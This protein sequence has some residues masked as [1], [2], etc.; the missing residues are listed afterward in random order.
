MLP[1]QYYRIELPSETDTDKETV[2]QL[3]ITLQ[4]VLQYEKTICPFRRGFT[5]DLPETPEQPIKRPTRVSTEPVKKWKLDKVW[6][7]EDWTPEAVQI[8]ETPLSRPGSVIMTQSSDRSASSSP[9]P[10]PQTSESNSPSLNPQTSERQ[11]PSPNTPTSDDETLSEED[12]Q[13]APLPDVRPRALSNMRSVTAPGKLNLQPVSVANRLPAIDLDGSMRGTVDAQKVDTIVEQFAKLPLTSD[14]DTTSNVLQDDSE[15]G[16]DRIDSANLEMDPKDLPGKKETD[17]EEEL[18]APISAVTDCTDNYCFSEDN[19]V[20]HPI[21]SKMSTPSLSS[22]SERHSWQD[23][24]TPPETIRLRYPHKAVPQQTISE[25]VLSHTSS[26]PPARR[27]ASHYAEHQASSGVVRKTFTI[28]TSPPSYLVNI[29][30]QMAGR[31]A[32]GALSLTIPS[33]QGAHRR[34]PGSWDLSDDEDVWANES[35]EA[36]VTEKAA[37]NKERRKTQMSEG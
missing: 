25:Q 1:E 10:N 33:P 9:S 3:K 32:N 11:S 36:Q 18:G 19:I 34:I 35:P 4:K 13:V 6:R 24:V 14:S 29:M 8:S 5:V 7:P 12:G 23:V 31:I 21:M 22:D 30:L 17:L 27:I 15:N 2:E 28:L 20:E 16:N 37:L 26:R